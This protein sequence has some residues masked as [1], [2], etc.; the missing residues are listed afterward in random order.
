MHAALEQR[1]RGQS[2]ACKTIVE[3]TAMFG[4]RDV[5]SCARV[6]EQTGVR[7][8]ACTGIY[9]YD[10]LPHYFANRSEDQMAEHFVPT[11]SRHPGHGHQAGFLKCAADEPG[12]TAERREGPPRGRARGL[13][14]GAP[15]MAHSRPASNTGP[16]QMEIFTRGGRRP[17]KVQIAH[18]GDTDD[19]D[20]IEGMLDKRRLDRPRPLR[21]RDVPAHGPAQRDDARAAAPRLRR[22]PLHRLGLLRHDRLVPDG[23]GEGL[24]EAGMIDPDWSMTLVFEKVLPRPARRRA[25]SPTRPTSRCSWTNP[26]PGC[27]LAPR[28]RNRPARARCD[29]RIRGGALPLLPG[30][31]P[32]AR[33]L[34][35]PPPP[36]QAGRA[37]RVRPHPGPGLPAERIEG[38]WTSGSTG[39]RRSSSPTPG[40]RGAQGPRMAARPRRH[41]AETHVAFVVLGLSSL[42]ANWTAL[43][44]RGSTPENLRARLGP[45]SPGPL[46]P[47]RR[48]QLARVDGL[49]GRA[50][51]GGAPA[52]RPLAVVTSADTLTSWGETASRS[53][54]AAPCTAGTGRSRPTPPWREHSRAN[55]ALRRQRA[56]RRT[57]R[58]PTDGRPCAPASGAG[59]WSPIFTTGA[60]P[61]PLRDRR[62]GGRERPSV[63]RQQR[64]WSASRAVGGDGELEGRWRSRSR[65]SAAP[66]SGLPR[67]RG[68]RG[69]PV[70]PDGPTRSRRG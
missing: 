49:G 70:R 28:A 42:P 41:P 3:P 64:R 22:P 4:G 9:T 12:V 26:R 68:D 23:G 11:S 40:G 48:R 69:V 54:S 46:H 59:S 34:R 37:G 47:V 8:V 6:A 24:F 18:T 5:S 35:R 21:P 1:Q 45:G 66:S 2:T 19:L 29:D 67:R 36:D 7:L 25:P 27:R 50:P 53:C 15:I 20:Y 57:S 30:T 31:P 62:R 56:A 44:M 33:P 17:E 51:P 65:G 52:T 58:W 13:Q 16:R 38:K 39:S 10:Y 63:P 61:N 14:T 60:S 43:S 32:P 55:G